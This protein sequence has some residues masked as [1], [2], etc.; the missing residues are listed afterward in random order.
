MLHVNMSH[1]RCPFKVSVK[2]I[3]WF[4]LIFSGMNC[5]GIQ[6]RLV[7]LP[8]SI[9]MLSLEETF[10]IQLTS[11]AMESQKKLLAPG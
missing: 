1:V 8:F 6:I 4:D 7:Q 11:I 3:N 9:D 2:N 5:Q 10:W